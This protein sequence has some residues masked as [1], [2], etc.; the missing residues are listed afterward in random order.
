MFFL[1][2][3]F[4]LVA[5][6]W[7]S[8]A[9]LQW[10]IFRDKIL[11]HLQFQRRRFVWG[12]YL[13]LTTSFFAERSLLRGKRWF[14]AN[15]MILLLQTAFDAVNKCPITAH[16]ERNRVLFRIW[17]Q[18]QPFVW[19]W[20][21]CIQIFHPFV[22]LSSYVPHLQEICN[23]KYFHT[24]YKDFPHE[25]FK[26]NCVVL[27]CIIDFFSSPLVSFMVQVPRIDFPSK[28]FICSTTH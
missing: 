25:R 24:K 11:F 19:P 3:K 16:R 20:K 21:Y 2:G 10:Y 4:T 13:T 8:K 22:T 1:W 9:G 18:V 12:L 27:I 26:K 5:L 23:S 28:L 6:A 17:I 15:W 7:K 14:G